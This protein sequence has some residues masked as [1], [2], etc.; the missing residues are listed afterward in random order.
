[1]IISARHRC[2]T[3]G[4]VWST[5]VNTSDPQ[6]QE[7]QKAMRDGKVELATLCESC[8]GRGKD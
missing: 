1:M 3:C 7:Q 5:P 6:W 2:P 8:R 4:Q